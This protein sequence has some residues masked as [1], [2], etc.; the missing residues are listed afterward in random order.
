MIPDTVT[1]HQKDWVNTDHVA[2]SPVANKNA[3]SLEEVVETS[4]DFHQ[5]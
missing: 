4:K 1:W 3:E 5:I 2:I